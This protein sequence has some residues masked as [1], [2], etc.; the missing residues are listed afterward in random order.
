MYSELGSNRYI[1]PKAKWLAR[2]QFLSWLILERQ[3][4]KYLDMTIF[5]YYLINISVQFNSFHKF[6]ISMGPNT[7]DWFYSPC[8]SNI[9]VAWKWCLNMQ[10]PHTWKKP[11][12][13]KCK[14]KKIESR[15]WNQQSNMSSDGEWYSA[16]FKKENHSYENL[17]LGDSFVWLGRGGGRNE[18]RWRMGRITWKC[19]IC[20]SQKF[21]KTF[22]TLW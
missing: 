14:C 6:M 20:F 17:N 3:R 7:S 18:H 15:F 5:Q 9:D 22:N 2:L 21:L 10:K 1:P 12:E 16:C 19:K 11:I 13:L 4:R 8:Y